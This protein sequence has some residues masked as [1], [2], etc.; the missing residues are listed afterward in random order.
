MPEL[1]EVE[2]VARTLRPLVQ[3]RVI[4]SVDALLMRTVADGSL[5][6]SLLV[7]RRIVDVQRR[8]KLVLIMLAP[9][10][11][12]V[13]NPHTAHMLAV[14]LKMTGRLFV[15]GEHEAPH[16]HT[17]LIVHMYTTHNTASPCRE[18]LFFD[19][20]R[21]FGYVRLVSPASL[22]LWNFWNT[23]GVEPLEC[24]P[25]V[26]AD[27]V[28]GSRA[29]IKSVLLNQTIVAGIGNIY[30]DEALFQAKIAPQRRV[31]TIEKHALEELFV[32]VQEVLR[33]SIAQCGSS[34][35]DYRTANGDAGAFQNTFRVYGRAGKPCV[36]CGQALHSTKVAGRTT[37]F[38][39]LCQV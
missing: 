6:L 26:L 16:K 36:C 25:A 30:A 35:R 33:L 38:C 3:G 1:P 21:T 8:G 22:G 29:S 27:A 37:V 18:Q 7:G 12:K 9:V 19:D 20:A 17:R 34:I 5:S 4:A 23:L 32:A 39:P 13:H 28:M 11:E 15:Y 14:H 2:T 24:S 31:C 10:S